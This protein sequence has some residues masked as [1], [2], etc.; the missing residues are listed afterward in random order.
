MAASS[1][2]DEFALSV[3]FSPDSGAV[4]KRL[5]LNRSQTLFI[6]RDSSGGFSVNDGRMSKLHLLIASTK[7]EVTCADAGSTNGTFVNGLPPTTVPLCHG[8][9]IRA[10]DTLFVLSL[11]DQMAEVQESAAL[12]AGTGFP[13]L[14]QGE[15][16]TGK[17]LVARSIH[18]KS[19]RA[20]PF[21][22][23]NCA[24]LPRELAAAELF[25][26]VRG[27]FSGAAN[28][29]PGLF[30]AA[31]GGTLFLDEIGDLPLEIQPAFLRVLE[32]RTVRPVG[33]DQEVS[34]DARLLAATHVD[35]ENA[36]RTNAFR[37]DLLAR[38][39][40]VVLRL[41]PL[42]ERRADLLSL[43]QEF[44]PG[45]R[46]SANAAEA[47]LLWNWPRNVRELRAV[48]EVAALLAQEEVVSLRSIRDRVPEA[49]DRVHARQR[50]PSGG[51]GEPGAPHPLVDRRERLRSLFE[52]HQ[53]NV[54]KVAEE[55]GKP[56]AQVYRWLKAL[57]LDA[58]QFRK[59]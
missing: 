49:A 53:G 48:V 34:V 10:G 32:E 11:R 15:T 4:G 22:P 47:L 46:F 2:R 29:R 36:V 33:A 21:V 54:S 27:A 20:G 3:V 24:T 17:E 5:V 19:G 6:G 59:G 43:A 31:A 7:T 37:A 50:E 44:S 35:L 38:L 52:A 42:R 57:G 12:V 1:R 40:H 28:A 9:I 55:L 58:D 8:D 56:R 41:P 18:Q 25:G 30:R 23:L 14:L 39:A 16:G 51:D 26:H 45:I 13:V